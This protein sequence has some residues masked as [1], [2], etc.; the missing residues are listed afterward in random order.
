MPHLVNKIRGKRTIVNFPKIDI[1][2]KVVKEGLDENGHIIDTCEVKVPFDYSPSIIQPSDFSIENLQ[3]A[4]IA[5]QHMNV[6]LDSRFGN[7]ENFNNAVNEL[8]S[9]S[10]EENKNE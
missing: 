8:S 5:P 10:N 2:T 1:Y 3:K 7:F 6:S 9:L 4:G